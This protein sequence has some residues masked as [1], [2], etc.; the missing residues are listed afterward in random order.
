MDI[1]LTYSSTPKWAVLKV[2]K[3]QIFHWSIHLGHGGV[4]VANYGKALS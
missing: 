1:P 3:S 2:Q 4:R